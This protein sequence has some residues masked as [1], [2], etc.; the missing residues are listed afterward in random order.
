[1]VGA[2]VAAFVV[3]ACGTDPTPASDLAD[4][5]GA[6]VDA[7]GGPAGDAAADAALDT[8]PPPPATLALPA[9]PVWPHDGLRVDEEGVAAAAGAWCA[10]GGSDEDAPSF[11]YG[12]LPLASVDALCGALGDR[13]RVATLLGDLYLSG[14]FGGVWFRDHAD[15]FGG[16]F[17][18]HGGS[19]EGG[20]TQ[21]DFDEIADNAAL[22]SALAA[23]GQDED[24]FAHNLESLSPMDGFDL[25]A[26]MD[27]L[28]VVYGYNYGYVEAIQANPPA[29]YPG[30]PE[31]LRCQGMLDCQSDRVELAAL[32]RF[33]VALDR[34][35]TRPNARWKEMADAVD[36]AQQWV[37]VGESLWSGGDVEPDIY[38]VLLDL[39]AGYL[40]VS[41]AAALG[42]MLGY[43][44]QDAD[45]GRCAL[46]VEAAADTWNRAYFAGLR[47]DLPTGEAPSVRCP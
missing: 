21:E 40:F 2:A 39:N 27:K 38:G 17:G 46:L 47:S 12:A 16:G 10:A 43:A 5:L 34:L 23:S 15:L 13:P 31:V 14:Y 7:V 33:R 41:G 35:A 29:D 6:D 28:L 20:M 11:F 45:A 25:D 1:V 22:L 3:A 8:P 42:S 18:S 32:E 4:G 44:D 37:S 36:D 9:L 26:M 19:S 24:V 30:D